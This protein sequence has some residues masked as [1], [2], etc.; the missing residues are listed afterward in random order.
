MKFLFPALIFA[1]FTGCLVPVNMEELKEENT[2]PRFLRDYLSPQF[3]LKIYQSSQPLVL[4]FVIEDPDIYDEIPFRIY[5]DYALAPETD[6][7]KLST[8]IV[9][10]KIPPRD[11][12]DPPIVMEDGSESIYVRSFHF[13]ISQNRFCDSSD[14]NGDTHQIDI[15]IA[16]AFDSSST[17]LPYWRATIGPSDVWTFTVV[18]TSSNK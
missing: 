11:P 15:V 9:T 10:D 13:P 2:P 7:A 17:R 1:I 18:C 8:V 12:E 14:S 4:T 6:S 3:I 5:K 16:D